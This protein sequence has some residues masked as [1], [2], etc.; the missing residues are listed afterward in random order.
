MLGFPCLPLKFALQEMPIKSAFKVNVIIP[1]R[2]SEAMVLCSTT[3]YEG[4]VV[5]S[6]T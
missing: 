5:T 3:Q 4:D 1:F 2:S 6:V